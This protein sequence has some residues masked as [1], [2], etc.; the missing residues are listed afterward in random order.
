MKVTYYLMLTSFTLNKA[1]AL[2]FNMNYFLD[3][4]RRSDSF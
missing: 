1:H 4:A 2:F 3:I